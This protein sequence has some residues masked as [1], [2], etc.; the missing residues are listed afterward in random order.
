VTGFRFELLGQRGRLRR[1]RY[2]TPHGTFETPCFAPV[3]TRASLKGLTP[4]QVRETG[5]ELVLANAYHL[6][7]RPGPALIA[8][9]GGLHRFMAWDGPILTDSGGYQVFSLSHLTA[10]DEDGVSFRSVVDGSPQRLTPES[11]LELQRDLGPDIAMVLDHCPAGTAE[12]DVVHDACARTLAWAER[13]RA[14]HDRW[15]GAARGQALFG[16]VQGGRDAGLRAASA[17]RLKALDFD[18]YAVGGLSVGETKEQMAIALDAAVAELPPD[19]LRYLMG[20]GTPEDFATAT[21][22]GVD[23]FDC[24]TPTRHGRNHQAF[25]RAGTLKLRN[26]QWAEDDLPLDPECHCYTCRTFSR[27]YLRHLAVSDEMLGGVLLS[28]HNVHYFQDLMRGIRD[29]V[30]LG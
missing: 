30:P 17:Q 18:G 11:A 4:A 27:A 21:A 7:L 1:G 16:I 22:A 15:G 5:T 8:R 28:L 23:L 9:R 19:R 14:L 25:T 12:P 24:V 29:A 10:I 3:G 6:L 13:A 26:L 20:V 2:H